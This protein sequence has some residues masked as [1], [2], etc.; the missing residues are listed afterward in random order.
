MQFN[1][2]LFFFIAMA[3]CVSNCYA[4]CILPAEITN[5]FK[6]GSPELDFRIRQENSKQQGLL[7]ASATTLRTTVGFET[8]EFYQAIFKVE[9]IDVAHFFGLHYNPG[10]SDM[11]LPQ[12]TLIPD[13][14]GAGITEIKLTYNG[15]TQNIFTLGRQYI[16]LDNQR[17]I[18]SN[19][20]RQ[21]P[22]SFDAISWSNTMIKNLELFY[23][24]VLAVNT[25]NA[26]GRAAEGK[27]QL[28][29]N[30]FNIDWT[31]FKY[32]GLGAYLYLNN[33]H[34]QNTNSN[35][36]FGIRLTSPEDLAECDYF[37]YWFEVAWQ[38]SQFNNPV[39]YNASY[40]HFF[41]SKTKDFLTG[42]LGFERLSGN[43]YA[44]NKVFIT[45]LGSVD[46]FNG[47]AEAFT[48]PP[49]RG[50]ND[51]YANLSGT[52]HDITIGL[53]YHF[54]L[55]DR[56]PG[57][58]LAGQEFD[59]YGDFK[60]TNQID[61]WIGYATYHAQNNAALSA[62]RFWVMITANLL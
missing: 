53:A 50:L 47:M 59:I 15:L 1:K 51:I 35:I 23:A 21:F 4:R 58:R 56:G 36:T 62:N 32:G 17:F 13:P 27:H 48:T 44:P 5:A 9:L 6:N 61:F 8:A 42:K 19:N 41:V 11:F 28:A 7:D 38:K 37:A 45:P 12:Y 43:A 24:F 54:F 49:A 40:M 2:V 29:T 46:E 31:G 60:V 22:Q 39:A 34:T 10:V 55:L 18:G 33:D 52:T 30:L 3:L 26:N 25:N 16:N 14:P 57:S 20:F